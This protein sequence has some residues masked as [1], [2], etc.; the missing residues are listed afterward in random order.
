MNNY[1]ETIRKNTSKIKHLTK[2]LHE[3]DKIIENNKSLKYYTDKY[4]KESEEKRKY[5]TEQE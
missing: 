2:K 3:K 4:I 5:S 1:E